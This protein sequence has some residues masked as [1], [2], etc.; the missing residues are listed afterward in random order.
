MM[1]GWNMPVLMFK[2]DEQSADPIF[3]TNVQ[4]DASGYKP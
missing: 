4:V 2:V 1:I 3:S